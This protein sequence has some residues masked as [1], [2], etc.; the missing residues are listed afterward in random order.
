MVPRPG[1][2]AARG[3]AVMRAKAELN[4]VRQEARSLLDRM[5][6]ARDII[7]KEL[8]IHGS[9]RHPLVDALLDVRNALR[10]ANAT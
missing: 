3:D 5:S 8:S 1:D 9:S 10:D 2:G 7:E 4:E 6:D